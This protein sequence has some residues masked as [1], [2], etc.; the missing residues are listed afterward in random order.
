MTREANKAA[1]KVALENA[2]K[3]LEGKTLGPKARF[4]ARLILFSAKRLARDIGNHKDAPRVS[5]FAEALED[6][7]RLSRSLT[8]KLE[9][10]TPY[11]YPFLVSRNLTGRDPKHDDIFDRPSQI[12]F[13]LFDNPRELIS[14]LQ[15]LSISV[16][17]YRKLLREKGYDA[18]LGGPT[19]NLFSILYGNPKRK[20]VT[21]CWGIFVSSRPEE[22]SGTENGDFHCFCN[23]VYEVATGVPGDSKGVGMPDLVKTVCGELNKLSQQQ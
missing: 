15:L 10:I 20:F 11:L 13:E 23:F 4:A 18:D 1:R 7:N 22:A 6:I 5:G 12:E 14:R 3:L 17:A 21:D 2:V 9:S 16:R 8:H 19:R